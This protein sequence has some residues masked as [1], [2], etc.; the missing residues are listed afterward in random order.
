MSSSEIPQEDN[1]F[2]WLVNRRSVD[3]GE[4]NAF[5]DGPFLNTDHD[6]TLIRAALRQHGIPA[7]YFGS[8]LQRLFDPRKARKQ[9]K[10]KYYG[11][12]AIT[13]SHS[14]VKPSK[15]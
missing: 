7:V 8:L 10:K 13:W 11:A 14:D 15:T 6:H 2:I 1:S 9:Q 4:G 12:R 3:N 5:V